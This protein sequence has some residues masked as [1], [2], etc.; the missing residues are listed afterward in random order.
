MFENI[1]VPRKCIE[2]IPDLKDPFV[3]DGKDLFEVKTCRNILQNFYSY[4]TSCFEKGYSVRSLLQCH[5][6]FLDEVLS[7]LYAHFSLDVEDKVALV[8]VGGY[9]RSEMFL[10]S[11]VDIFIAVDDDNIDLQLEEKIGSFISYLWDIKL[12][13]GSSVRTIQ[14]AITQS[15]SDITIRTNLL[16][17]RLITGSKVCFKRLRER[18]GLDEFWDAERFLD[19]KVQEQ[20]ERY[21]QYRDTVY[22]IEPDVK[23]NLGGLRD[24]QLVMWIAI[25]T[26]RAVGSEDFVK[27]GLLTND[28]YSEFCACVDFLFEVRFALHICSQGSNRLTLDTQKQTAALL[29][30]GQNGNEPVETMMRE[31]FRTFRRVHELSNMV[32]QLETLKI[33]GQLDGES[34]PVF[35]NSFF[36]QRG[37]YIDILDHELFHNDPGKI[38]EMFLQIAKHHEIRSIHVHCLRALRNARRNLTQFFIE[39]PSC[40]RTFKEILTIQDSLITAIPLMHETRV[41][42]AYMPQWSRIEGLTQFDM[43]HLFSVDEHTVRALSNLLILQKSND[44]RFALFTTTMHHLSEP[45]LLNVAAFLHDIAKGRGGHHAEEGA[46]E[47]YNFCQLHNF[48]PFQTELIAWTVKNHLLYSNTATRRDIS[49]PEV[50]NK[51]AEEVRDE[52]H[53]N[54]L[55]CMTVADITATNE[56]EWNSWKD[57][58]FKQLYMATRQVLRRGRESV[59]DTS[60]QA[61]ENQQLIIENCPDLKKSALQRYFS[62]FPTAY[63]LHY[64]PS[65]IRWHVR[66]ILRFKEND[67]PLILFSQLGNLG[68]ELLIYYR[69][70]SPLF[71][72]NIATAMALKH[73]NVYSAQIF[74][75]RHSHTL[76]TIKFQTRKN[77]PLDNDRL[78]SLRQ[79]ILAQL[80]KDDANADLAVSRDSAHLFM[81]PTKVNFLSEEQTSH[82]SV[83]ISTLDG[84]G[85]LAKIGMTLGKCSCLITAARIT[86]TGERADDFFT[87][88]DLNGMPLNADKKAELTEALYRALDE[89]R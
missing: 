81:V 61:Q 37:K 51:F 40:R 49:D 52:E 36:V 47:A 53:L 82:S 58:I 11:D 24:L 12:D 4:L 69:S 3:Y 60:L 87:V 78:H 80:K 86:T 64:T 46:K 34:D 76:C 35:L 55:Y 75:T 28:E 42:S 62:Q 41:L 38:I 22:S 59:L 77:L 10:G 13:L 6:H 84:E 39:H 65:E 89:K 79:S 7:K 19:A 26:D 68:T 83:E 15:H 14:D 66:N 31:L 48:A 43:F 29:G 71:F 2:G 5:T 50:I 70:S 23:N 33:K 9:G 17:N 44:P 32:L 45:G 72:G 67:R 18:F 73:L 74:K 25:L 56:H 57:S 85:L 27:I 88:T 1:K 20:H 54:M 16:E 8:A 63:F 30:Y 21:H